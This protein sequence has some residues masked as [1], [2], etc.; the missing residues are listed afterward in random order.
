M[1]EWNRSERRSDYVLDG[2][3]FD[4]RHCIKI[5]FQVVFQ[6][7]LMN[8]ALNPHIGYDK[9]SAIAKKAHKDGTT[10]IEAGGPKGLNYFTEQQFAEWVKPGEMVGPKKGEPN[11]Y[12][13]P[14][15]DWEQDKTS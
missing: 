7:F 15:S 3:L 6:R 5:L 10:L 2:K 1:R 13:R 14:K 12:G 8:E 9:A 4:A 11:F